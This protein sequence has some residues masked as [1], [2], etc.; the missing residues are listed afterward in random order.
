MVKCT[1][2]DI[3]S[4][5]KTS[6]AMSLKTIGVLLTFLRD[7]FSFH[8][9]EKKSTRKLLI[10]KEKPFREINRQLETKKT[11]ASVVIEGYNPIKS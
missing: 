1:H 7:A 4:A 6:L 11:I 10:T 2:I 3:F 9:R 5:L 8:C